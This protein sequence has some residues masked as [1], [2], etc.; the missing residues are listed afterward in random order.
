MGLE[1]GIPAMQTGRDM[2]EGAETV[3]GKAFGTVHSYADRLFGV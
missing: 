2:G 1:K 3:V